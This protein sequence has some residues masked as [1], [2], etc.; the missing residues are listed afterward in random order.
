MLAKTCLFKF[1]QWHLSFLSLLLPRPRLCP[2]G[3]HV[4][5]HGVLVEEPVRRG[6][7]VGG[8][9]VQGEAVGAAVVQTVN[10]TMPSTFWQ[11]SVFRSRYMRSLSSLLGKLVFT[12]SNWR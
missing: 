5:P 10:P 1:R 7:V 3:R 4:D 11:S 6:A 8:T 2:G 9:V 12:S